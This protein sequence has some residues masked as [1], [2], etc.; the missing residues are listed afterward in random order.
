MRGR[1]RPNSGAYPTND[2]DDLMNANIPKNAR[3]FNTGRTNR[4]TT[5]EPKPGPVSADQTGT[6]KDLAINIDNDHVGYGSSSLKH[7]EP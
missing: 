2:A 1:L 5:I 7:P 6:L 4:Q 3:I